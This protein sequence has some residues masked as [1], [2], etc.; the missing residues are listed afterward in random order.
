MAPEPISFSIRKLPAITRP[1]SGSTLVRC[2]SCSGGGVIEHGDSADSAGHDTPKPPYARVTPASETS[3]DRFTRGTPPER[4]APELFHSFRRLGWCD[5][6][7][8][9][10]GRCRG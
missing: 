5:V 3:G 4:D 2:E 10:R 6:R 8:S 9:R 7:A 1:G